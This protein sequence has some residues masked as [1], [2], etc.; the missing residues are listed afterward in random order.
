MTIVQGT[1]MFFKQLKKLSSEDY[2]EV[3]SEI[4]LIKKYGE[5]W[6]KDMLSSS[7]SE[8]YDIPIMLSDGDFV[9]RVTMEMY[10]TIKGIY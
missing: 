2:G 7:G 4:E 5:S 3:L 8:H 6:F 10:I 9:M 1:E